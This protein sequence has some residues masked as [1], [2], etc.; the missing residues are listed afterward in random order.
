M[1]PE[2][3]IQRISDNLLEELGRRTLP[4]LASDTNRKV[5]NTDQGADKTNFVSVRGKLTVQGTDGSRH[6]VKFEKYANRDMTRGPKGAKMLRGWGSLVGDRVREAL[7]GKKVEE[8]EEM[9]KEEKS[10]KYTDLCVSTEGKDDGYLLYTE[11]PVTLPSPYS[12]TH[13]P[14]P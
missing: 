3:P 5:N 9:E 11:L 12:A 13:N 6:E 14:A 10:E 1:K 8:E 2:D 4:P 7:L